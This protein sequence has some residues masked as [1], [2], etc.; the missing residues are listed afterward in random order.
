MARVS[1]S[2]LITEAS[3]S[4]A[5]TVFSRWKGR[6]YIRAR[7]TPA[8]PNT[9]AQQNVRNSLARCVE[10]WQSIESDE[11][12]R[13]DDYA[14]PY[15]MSGYNKFMSANRA[16]EQDDELLK[17]MPHNEDADPVTGFSASTGAG[18]GEID[19][20]WSDPGTYT[21]GEVLVVTRESGTNEF[22]VQDEDSTLVTAESLTISG[23]TANTEYDVYI[24]AYEQGSDEY[25]ESQAD[26][27]TS[28]TA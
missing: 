19:L 23:L 13:W 21:T 5:D 25:S 1:Y 2:P 16:D 14:S 11:K 9:T 7:V 12:S 24:C 6:D 3:G 28:G 26:T 20:T 4:V 27:A 15:Q 18:E 22:V 10:L 17:F 8:N